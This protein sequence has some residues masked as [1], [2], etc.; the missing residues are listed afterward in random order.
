MDLKISFTE[1]QIL[2]TMILPISKEGALHAI[3]NFLK[4]DI[5]KVNQVKVSDIKNLDIIYQ[6]HETT[7]QTSER[8]VSIILKVIKTIKN[9]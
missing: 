1:K 5:I 6:K 3:D 7:S 9:I 8:I 2:K 4:C